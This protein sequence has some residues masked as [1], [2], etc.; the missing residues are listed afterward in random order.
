MNIKRLF[1]S[2][3]MV[4]IALLLTA[5]GGGG[6]SVGDSGG[7]NPSLTF[8][9]DTTTL[10]VLQ[11]SQGQVAVNLTRQNF[12]GQVNF[13]LKGNALLATSPAPDKIAWSFNPNPTTGNQTTLT[14]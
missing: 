8:S 4:G 5:C 1:F 6:G 3:L 7:S 9:L 14:L 2:F 10:T 13:S 11:G 12:T